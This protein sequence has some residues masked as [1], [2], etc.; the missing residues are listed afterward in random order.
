M[1]AWGRISILTY[2]NA[3]HLTCKPSFQSA[4]SPNSKLASYKGHP[5]VNITEEGL[6]QYIALFHDTLDSTAS[7]FLPPEHHQ[8]LLHTSLLPA[9]IIGYVS[10]QFGAAIEYKPAEHTEI[11]IVLGS[12]RVEDLFVQAPPR[13][14]QIGPMIQVQEGAPGSRNDGGVFRLT[15]DGGFPFRLLGPN[16]GFCV[17]EV[18]FKIGDWRRE[19]AFAEVFGNR[20]VEFW[21]KEQAISRAKDEVLAALAQTKRAS[22]RK[23][24]LPEYIAKF[25]ERT[26]LLLGDYDKAGIKRLQELAVALSARG[27]DPILIKD[28]PD[29]AAQDL[30]QKVATIG[31]LARFVLVDDST[32]SGHLVEAQLCRTN[33]WITV[34]LRQGGIGASWMTAGASVTSNVVSEQSYDESK[35]KEAV[36]EAVRWAEAKILELGR[37]FDRIF[38]WRMQG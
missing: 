9:R 12:A 38:P 36:D 30:P 4:G 32:K 1:R 14:R 15:L 6:R 19:V 11:Q 3:L 8:S 27:Y 18:A 34:L 2:H 25:K 29:V 23:L 7:Q 31:S 26:V 21:S 35:S 37:K 22:E 20:T 5:I 16:S 33:N 28:V 24:T 10:T 17:G 13:A